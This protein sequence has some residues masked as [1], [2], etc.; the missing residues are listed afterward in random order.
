MKNDIKNAL[1]EVEQVPL[2][3][4]DNKKETPLFGLRRT[5]NGEFLSSCSS[6]YT[7]TQNADLVD[8]A[9][10]SFAQHGLTQ[11]TKKAV[12]KG[13][14]ARAYITYDFNSL[15]APVT[16]KPDDVL[17]LQITLINSFDKTLLR[18]LRIGMLRL[19]CTN[20]MVGM[21]DDLFLEDRHT[22]NNADIDAKK[23]SAGVEKAVKNFSGVINLYKRMSKI[24]ITEANADSLF[25]EMVATNVVRGRIV[26]DVRKIWNSPS[27]EAD[28]ERTLYNFLNAWTQHLD[29][30]HSAYGAKYYETSQKAQK[31]VFK[32][33]NQ[34]MNRF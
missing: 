5:D 11:Y 26:G 19:I 29:S 13:N 3:Y 20:G 12:V 1:Y 22:P 18:G 21:V 14:G 9:E 6:R 8:V 31:E 4:S 28:E 10:K 34:N 23:F 32:F 30:P 7:I 25:K 16:K 17:G 33:V 15:I 27:F 24:K 2:I